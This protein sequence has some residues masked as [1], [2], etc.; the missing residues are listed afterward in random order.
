MHRHKLIIVL[1]ATAVFVGSA[2]SQTTYYVDVSCGDDAWTGTDPNC[3]APDGPKVTIQAAINVAGFHDEILVHPGTY[4]ERINMLG[5]AITLRSTDGPALTIID[6]DFGGSVITCDSGE[7]PDRVIEGFTVTNGQSNYGGGVYIE[8]SSP[9]L[10]NCTFSGNSAIATGGGICSRFNCSPTLINCSFSGNSATYGGGMRDREGSPTLINCTF[11][12]NAA[13]F[14]GG[15]MCNYYSNPTLTN[16]TFSGNS[17]DFHGGGIYSWQYSSPTLAN[18]IIWGNTALNGPQIYNEYSST[19]TASYSCIAGGWTGTGNIDSD[20]L[21]VDADGIDDI[22][23]TPD[24]D[25]HLLDGSPC[26]DAGDNS[27]VPIEVTTDLDGG[28]RFVDDPAT[29][30][31]GQ[32]TPPIVD[33]GAYE[34]RAILGAVSLLDHGGTEL[35]LDLMDNNIE[36]RIDGVLKIEFELSGVV[37]S[38]SASVSC[39]NNTYSGTITTTPNGTA[40]TV[41]FDP[42][43]PD[44]DCCG[45]TLTGDAVDGLW[46]RTLEG[47]VN[48]DGFTNTTDASQVKLRFGQTPT[49]ANCEWDFNVD[50]EINTTDASQVKL[51]F[52]FTAPACP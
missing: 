42:A 48:R 22:F 14:V 24:D 16:C 23:G 47:D 6:G 37:V 43:L 46:V 19:T 33:M 18:C 21:F 17:A 26:I 39:V 51:R 34:F 5:K 52:G 4:V 8:N 10:I 36:P 41:E 40:V 45:M 38:A 50:G 28:P 7:G 12:G 15:G 31:T 9:T 20:P 27:A 30:D 1:V 35:G 32:G 49:N 11:S 2:H 3:V 44:Q 29:P 13:S 25:L